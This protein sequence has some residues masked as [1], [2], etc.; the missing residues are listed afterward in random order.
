MPKKTRAIKK[1]DKNKAW[2][3]K[4]KASAYLIE[5]KEKRKT[6]LI[7]TEGQTE[8][9]YFESFPVLTLTVKTINLEGE[10]KLKLINSTQEIISN[11]DIVFDEVWCVFDMD[12]KLGGDELS[13]YDNAIVKGKEL[14]YNI[15]YSNDAF[16]LWF[17]LHYNYT[18]EQNLRKFYYQKLSEAWGINYEKDGKKYNF[19]KSIYSK[20]I[21]DANA[22]QSDAI[23]RSKMLYEKQKHL[24][25]NQQNPITKVYE[26][27]E[28]L[29]ENLRE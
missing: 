23:H 5:R 9:L 17:Y 14:G 8:K 15:A 18:E 11:L 12:I 25:Y 3:K 2:N 22:S 24:P 1:T 6:I 10:S 13:S 27:V 20:L 29:N 21:D 19:C 28:F 4:S 26:L 16:E 7:L